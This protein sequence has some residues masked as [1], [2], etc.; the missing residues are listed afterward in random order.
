MVTNTKYYIMTKKDSA[1]KETPLDK[2]KTIIVIPKDAKYTSQDIYITYIDFWNTFGFIDHTCLLAI[3]KD[4]NLSRDAIKIIG[5]IYA[6]SKM[7]FHGNYYGTT[8]QIN[9]SRGTH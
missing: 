3:M 5:D 6:N 2:S 4:L 7:A 8:T 9:I 1:H